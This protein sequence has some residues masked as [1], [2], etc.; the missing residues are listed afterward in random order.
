VSLDDGD[1]KAQSKG[2][3]KKE[4]SMVSPIPETTSPAETSKLS[5]TKKPS[6]LADD[7]PK[8]IPLPGAEVRCEC[9]DHLEKIEHDLKLDI[10]AKRLFDLLFADANFFTAVHERGKDWDIKISE[11]S[12]SSSN[13]STRDVRWMLS[14]NNPMVKLKETDCTEVQTIL[15]RQEHMCY[16]VEGCARTPNMPYGDA[17]QTVARYCIM[18]RSKSTS[19]LI[20][21]IGVRFSKS[22]MVKSRSN[23]KKPSVP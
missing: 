17:F 23:L 18:Y 1:A 8:D 13:S 5:S 4:K 9:A 15:K 22:V 11:W 14:V 6:Q 3:L 19:R 20:M 7:W 21:S 2:T 12:Q 10:S 16:I